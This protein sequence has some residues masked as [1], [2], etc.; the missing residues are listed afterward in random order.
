MFVGRYSPS[1]LGIAVI[2]TKDS[3][4]FNGIDCLES[5]QVQSIEYI[6]SVGMIGGGGL[7]VFQKSSYQHIQLS[8]NSDTT[9]SSGFRSINGI[10][11]G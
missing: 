10:I 9:R 1:S 7:H 2:I 5:I 11:R 6:I 4:D 3:L 8:K